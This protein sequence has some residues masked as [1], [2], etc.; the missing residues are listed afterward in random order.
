MRRYTWVLGSWACCSWDCCSPVAA[1]R[2]MI[3][4]L[5][6]ALATASGGFQAPPQAILLRAA[7]AGTSP[8]RMGRSLARG[9]GAARVGLC[10]TTRNAGA[11]AAFAPPGARAQRVCFCRTP[12]V[13]SGEHCAC[14][15]RRAA[16]LARPALAGRRLD[17]P[18]HG[19]NYVSC[20]PADVGTES[21]ARRRCGWVKDHVFATLGV[22]VEMWRM[23]LPGASRARPQRAHR[24]RTFLVHQHGWSRRMVHQF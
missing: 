21:L 7:E 23:L 3:P 22:H 20:C 10:M 14:L 9:A 6:A 16:H 18:Q 24:G 2:V 1:R 17:P 19:A 5:V 13:V 12:L 8:A 4:I 15:S 11:S